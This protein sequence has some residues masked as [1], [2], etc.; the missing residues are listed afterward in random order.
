MRSMRRLRRFSNGEPFLDLSF[1]EMT[2]MNFTYR[3]ESD[4]LSLPDEPD[5]CGNYE[6]L[7]LAANR[8]DVHLRVIYLQ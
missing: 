2:L 8:V 7:I 1:L 4:S 3:A 6:S 5:C